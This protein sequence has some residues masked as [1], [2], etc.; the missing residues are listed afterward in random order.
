MNTTISPEALC[1]LEQKFDQNP[2]HTVAMN[3]VYTNGINACARNYPVDRE[4]TH[5]YSISLTQGKITNQ[6]KSGRCWMF[7]ALNCLRFAL[8][9]KCNLETFELSQSYTLFMISWK[10][11]TTSSKASSTP[12]TKRPAA[13]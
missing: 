12:S 7:A 4:I 11:P 13:A 3:A 5:D 8:M 10:N 6:K 1:C 9:K 2:V